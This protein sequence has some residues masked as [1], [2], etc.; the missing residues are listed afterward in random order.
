[1]HDTLAVVCKKIKFQEALKIRL[2]CASTR[3]FLIFS[4]N[5]GEPLYGLIGRL[6]CTEKETE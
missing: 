1:M 2:G 6:N 5:E 4:F 3:L